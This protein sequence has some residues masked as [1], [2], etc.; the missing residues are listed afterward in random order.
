MS[1]RLLPPILA[2]ASVVFSLGL[3]CAMPFAGLAAQAALVVSRRG[4]VAASLLAWAANQAIGYG[5]LAYPVTV[6]S[7]GWG[8]ALG[9]AAVLATLTAHVAAATVRGLAR[10][11]A[12]FAAA[13]V[14]QQG[15]VFAARLALPSHPDA[16][17]SSVVLSLLAINALAFASLLAVCATVPDLRRATLTPAP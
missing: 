9:V 5:L 11:I 2:L 10:P 6:G 17:T 4:A 12:A 8:I 1:P 3:A 7:M 13:F 14:A 16:F 15:V